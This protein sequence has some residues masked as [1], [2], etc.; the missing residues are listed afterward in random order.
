MQFF[1]VKIRYTSVDS[2][3]GKEVIK[4]ETY[5]V[6]AVSFTDA[7]TIITKEAEQFVKGEMQVL[8]IKR[9]NIAKI[10]GDEDAERYYK[11][12]LIIISIADSGHKI[13]TS[14]Y[15]LVKTDNIGDVKECIQSYMKDV[16]TEWEVNNISESPII[17]VFL[18]DEYFETIKNK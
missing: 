12:K 8:T 17:D 5:L 1:E 6:W 18:P 9:S 7:E 14:E 16:I 3:S 11:A 13:T 4:R 15:I 10:I 2:N